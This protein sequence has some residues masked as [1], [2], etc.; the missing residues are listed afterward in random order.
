MDIDNIISKYLSRSAT[1]EEQQI[2][3]D[4][5]DEKEENR[6]QFKATYDLWLYTNASLTDDA[7]MEAAFMRLKQRVF[8]DSNAKKSA[9][10]PLY[11]SYLFRIAASILLL[12]STGYLGYKIGDREEQKAITMNHLLTGTG[13]KGEYRLPDG[14]SVWLNANSVLTY[15]ATFTGGKRMVHLEGEAL[16]EVQQDKKNPF[17]V[18]AGGLNI[19]VVGTRF[20]MCNYSQKNIVQAVLV[21][22][23][24]KVSGDY[25]EEPRVLQPGELLTY[26]KKTG[27]TELSEVNTDDY[28]NWIYSRLVF[29][30]TNLAKVIVNLGKWYDVEIKAS[31]ELLQN[32]HMSFTIRRESL[33]EVLKNISL[34]AQIDHYW[35]DDV[36]YLY[37]KE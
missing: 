22:G 25:F 15:P 26:N 2:L 29:D 7:E 33:E 24:V 28:T 23:S 36:L 16:F 13:G 10:L 11:R 27:E 5:L 18:T 12:F 4:W 20:L 30:K 1:E 31:P 34:T 32:T 21:N 9:W 6:V 17:F 3:L 8:S 14:S 19:E 37:P 35:K